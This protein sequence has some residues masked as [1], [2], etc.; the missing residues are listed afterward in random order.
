MSLTVRR[1]PNQIACPHN[2]GKWRAIHVR[3][4]GGDRRRIYIRFCRLCAEMQ[5][6]DGPQR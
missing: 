1:T 4:V 3:D 6:L 2:F 5:K